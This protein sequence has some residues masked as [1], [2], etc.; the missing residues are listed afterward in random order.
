MSG[1]GGGGKGGGSG[2]GGTVIIIKKKG[3]HGG[4]HGG[5]W[6]VAYADFVTAMM[7]L[8]M[9]LWLVSQTDQVERKVISH[10]FRTGVFPEGGVS[11][12]E[13]GEGIQSGTS[14]LTDQEKIVEAQAEQEA[15][16][17]AAE[18]VTK[19]ALQQ[20]SIDTTNRTIKVRTV[21]RGLLIE[22]LDGGDDMFFELS[23]SALKPKLVQLLEA[24]APALAALK[25]PLEVH[26]HT[27]ARPFP[28]GAGKDN[29]VLSFERA[30]AAR[31]ILEK[32]GVPEKKFH[33][34][35]AHAATDLYVADQPESPL[36]RRIAILALRMVG[37]RPGGL[38]SAPTITKEAFEKIGAEPPKKPGRN[39]ARKS[40]VDPV[41]PSNP[42]SSEAD[43]GTD[44]EHA[45]PKDPEREQNDE[46]ESGD[47]SNSDEEADP[48]EHEP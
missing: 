22:I 9:V 38:S 35:F 11:L 10:Y 7:A 45:T 37:R 19:A 2:K 4:H 29:W 20:S 28:K 1:G 47:E 32:A 26:G 16:Q 12:I 44:A 24:M 14:G 23:S 5:A 13:M 8:F 33:G 15:L 46:H 31:S 17:K 25:N 6:K 42:S 3:G 34:V 41:K 48:E 39:W 43:H 21:D 27:D 30:A 18:S 40:G 36:N